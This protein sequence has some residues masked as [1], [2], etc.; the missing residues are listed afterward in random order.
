MREEKDAIEH[1]R[2]LL[3]AGKHARR[4]RS[5]GDRQGDQE[6]RQQIRRFRQ[7][8]PGTGPRRTLD[9]HHHRRSAAGDG[10]MAAHF[11][12]IPCE[13]HGCR[14]FSSG[15]RFMDVRRRR[16]PSG[17]S[18][19]KPKATRSCPPATMMRRWIDDRQ[20]SAMD[21]DLRGRRRRRFTKKPSASRVRCR[22]GIGL[23]GREGQR[24]WDH[25]VLLEDTD[26]AKRNSDARPVADDGR[27]HIGRMAG[28]GRRSVSSGDIM[29]EIETDKAT[30]EFEAVD[31]GTDRQ[32]PS[33]RA[34]RA[35]RSTHRSPMPAG[36]RRKRR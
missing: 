33:P 30:M 29:A 26:H 4:G 22:Q 1:V 15:W 9:G 8:K 34:P 25:R 21:V 23:R 16:W 12:T 10:V 18:W 31:E 27:R 5:Q 17:I 6:H 24:L 32:D 20:G 11:E 35:S 13:R 7:G 36:R 28:Q 2:D 19:S 14:P 3:M